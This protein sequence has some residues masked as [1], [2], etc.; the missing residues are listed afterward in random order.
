MTSNGEKTY[1]M[2]GWTEFHRNRKDLLAEFDRAKGY[3]ASRRVRME[4]GIAGEADIRRWLA[5]YVPSKFGVTS[6]YIIPD[7]VVAAYELRHFDVII[8]DKLSAPVLWMDG[9]RDDSDQGKKRA[10]PAKYVR[11]VFEVK[12]SL[13]ADAAKEA[14]TKLEQLNELA[15]YLPVGFSCNTVFY[16]LDVALLDKQNIL[17][18]LIPAAPIIGYWGGVVL[19][20][21]LDDEMTGLIQLFPKAAH[22]PRPEAVSVPLAKKLDT[23]GISR[24]PK[25]NL[26]LTTGG[27]GVMAFSDGKAYHFTKLYGPTIYGPQSELMLQWSHNSFARF[28]LDLLSRLD[29]VPPDKNRGYVFGQVF[30][31]I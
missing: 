3:N 30:D 5:G 25:G 20:C 16:D 10:I 27:A 26:I 9:N 21:L 18:N 7:I 19:R 2:F 11:A 14:V 22:E 24:D 6:G 1:G 31:V 4:H 29:G 23:V 8:Y 15:S 17:P 28:A 12:A 13:T